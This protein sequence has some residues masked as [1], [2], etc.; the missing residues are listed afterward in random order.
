MYLDAG[1]DPILISATGVN[2]GTDRWPDVAHKGPIRSRPS[3]SAKRR[4]EW[5]AG[6]SR[7]AAAAR[8]RPVTTHKTNH[9][10]NRRDRSR[11]PLRQRRRIVLRGYGCNERNGRRGKRGGSRSMYLDAGADPI[12]ISATGVNPGTD[13]CFR[14]AHKGPI[15]SRPS[16]SAKRR[17]ERRAGASREAAAARIRPITSNETNH[18]WTRRGRS[19]LPLRPRRRGSQGAKKSGS[20]GKLSM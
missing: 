17:H 12:L 8:I 3:S 11:L 6:A 2:P 19:R 7:E 9:R 4:H 1:A 13:R 20:T 14:V 5:R 15:R 10:W 16:S 18:R